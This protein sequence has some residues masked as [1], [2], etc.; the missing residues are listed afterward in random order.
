MLYFEIKV[1]TEMCLRIAVMAWKTRLQCWNHYYWH[2]SAITS[3]SPAWYCSG[4]KLHQAAFWPNMN[5][6]SS[7]SSSS[8][9]HRPD[10]TPLTVSLCCLWPLHRLTGFL[11]LNYSLTSADQEHP[12][13]AAVLCSDLVLSP[14]LFGSCQ[15]SHSHTPTFFS[16]ST[17]QLS[18]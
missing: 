6:F 15:T 1:S 4:T 9:P 13:R 3:Q 10:V 12:T 7:F 11:L 2:S 5:F 17:H 18:G 16:A 8:S 14:L